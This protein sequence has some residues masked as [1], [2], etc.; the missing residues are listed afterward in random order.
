MFELQQSDEQVALAEALRRL[1]QRS[2]RGPMAHGGVPPAGGLAA[3]WAALH[4]MGL[5]APVGADRPDPMTAML[6]AE[7][8]GFGDPGLAYQ[9]VC[10]AR[11]AAMI[12][13]LGTGEQRSAWLP[14][15]AA[16]P[17]CLAS[18]GYF[19][20][21]GRSPLEL[22]T[23]ARRVGDGWRLSGTK[24][25]VVLPAGGGPL[26]LVAREEQTGEPVA[27]VL[28]R[29]FGVRRDDAAVGKLGL[30]AAATGDIELTEVPV[31][32]SA[33]LAGTGASVLAAVAALRLEV[34]A[35]LLGTARAALAYAAEYANGREAFGQPI[36]GYQGVAFPLVDVDIELDAARLLVWRASA[37]VADVAEVAQA[38][39]FGRAARLVAEAVAR[40]QRVALDA[41]R[42]GINTL[43]GHG[44][45]Q[46]HPVEQWY[47]AAAVLAA[48]DFDPL[49]SDC[50]A[51]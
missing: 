14:R 11:A 46:D 34:T 49:E 26:V 45:I 4:Q 27:F 35:V 33:R 21:F 48:L 6:I 2:V 29:E 1:A 7:E 17:G 18:V 16:D 3:A 37:E 13:D 39:E 31:P 20:G 24:I 12:A 28:T 43:G 40:G 50:E 25:G 15:L 10:R 5:C 36:A 30:D 23:S 32:E 9:L 8:V 41:T 51:F 22:R 19:E 47:R 38:A 44:F 42:V